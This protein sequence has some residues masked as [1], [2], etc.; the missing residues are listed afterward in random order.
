[1]SLQMISGFY[2]FTLLLDFSLSDKTL[3]LLDYRDNI[4]IPMLF[5]FNDLFK[6]NVDIM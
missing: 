4:S 6:H 5:Y 1:M 2:L 3:R